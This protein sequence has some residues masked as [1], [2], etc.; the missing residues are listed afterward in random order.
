MIELLALPGWKTPPTTLDAWRDK[1]S[2]EGTPVRIERDA[3]G[4]TWIEVPAM[5]LRGFVDFEG[6]HV[7]AINFELHDPNAEAGTRLIESAAGALAWEVFPDDDDV[8]D[9]SEI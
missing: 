3:D 2:K 4:D 5:R 6:E 1:L 8:E 9:S 7:G